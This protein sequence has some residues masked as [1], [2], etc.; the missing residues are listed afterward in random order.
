MVGHHNVFIVKAKNRLRGKHMV[1]HDKP[2][3]LTG[4]FFFLP[5]LI[6]LCLIGLVL[7][8]SPVSAAIIHGTIYDLDLTTLPKTVVDISTTPKQRVVSSDGTY[9]FTVD[10]G[11]YVIRAQ[12]KDNNTLLTT[13]EQIV[14]KENGS[15]VFDLFLLL[16]FESEEEIAGDI[17]IDVENLFV[18][19]I[20]RKTYL[21]F[22]IVTVLVFCVIY[23]FYKI[24][25]NP[26]RRRKKDIETD[27]ESGNEQ[28]GET[29]TPEDEQLDDAVGQQV[30]SA[31]RQNEGRLTQKE[32][33]KNIPLSEA[34]ISLVL[35]DLETQGKIRKIKKGRGN[36]I[37]LSN[38]T[39][40]KED[41][42]EEKQQS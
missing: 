6:F 26:E 22:G 12:H 37:V 39:P 13:E 16:S 5:C 14:I 40:K 25:R 32:L 38:G 23:L 28:T 15:Y 9:A 17:S 42:H 34:K 30:L 21:I 11:T 35:T 1:P 36:I 20:N 18:E 29:G 7:F 2:H 4:F 41:A 24:L 10:K 33:R 31:L 8:T 19:E 3:H 27:I